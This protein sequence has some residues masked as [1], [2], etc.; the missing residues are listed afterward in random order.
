MGICYSTLRSIFRK[1]RFQSTEISE[2]EDKP[3]NTAEPKA[4]RNN[5]F[6]P[7]SPNNTEGL[8]LEKS[9][10]APQTPKGLLWKA[11]K[12]DKTLFL[13]GSF[14]LGH[15]ALFPLSPPVQQA[16]EQSS[17]IAVEIDH[18]KARHL[19]ASDVSLPGNET[20]KNHL[21]PQT[22]RNLRKALKLLG[23][24][25]SAFDRFNPVWAYIS[26]GALAS[27]A[28]GFEEKLSLNE[29]ILKQKG[30]KKVIE[31]IGFSQ[32][33][34][35]IQNIPDP[36]ALI[37]STL[38]H[39]YTPEK[40]QDL[41]EGKAP[42]HSATNC[43][44][45]ADAQGYYDHYVKRFAEAQDPVLQNLYKHMN[46]DNNAKM[47]QKL[48]ASLRNNKPIFV[49]VGVNH[50]VGTSSMVTLLEEKGYTVNQ[51]S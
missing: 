49:A 27:K 42:F 8:S 2:S 41:K 24:K 37:Q 35:N 40:I 5:H 4:L 12:E 6:D 30:N 36:S 10:Q 7:R 14:Q 18:S 1:N 45:S 50:L 19:Q 15:S 13:F 48:E 11:E 29:H 21:S 33:L 17:R 51:V 26:L 28:S 20:I 43:W 22:Y 3:L 39:N 38:Q 47:V 25:P 9:E 46:T 32:H 34:K 31:L 44:I 23:E 16:L